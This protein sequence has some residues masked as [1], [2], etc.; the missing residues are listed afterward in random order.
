MIVPLGDLQYGSEAC[1]FDRFKRHVEWAVALPNAYFLGMGD[2]VDFGSPSNRAS[3]R[4]LIEKGEL[5]DTA[6]DLV[7]N[8]AQAHLEELLEV[9][10][11][12][13]GRWLG[14]LEGHH[15]WTFADGTTSDTRLCQALGAPFLGT[16]ALVQVRFRQAKPTHKQAPSFVI[17]CHHGRGSGQMQG[18]PLN[19]LEQVTKAF[20]ADVYL[21]GHHH[22]KASA[23][24]QRLA[25]I[26]GPTGKGRLL[27]KNVIIAGTGG[28]LK[29]YMQGSKRGSVAR[30]GYVEQGM[31]V[32]VALGGVVIWARPKQE[33][34]GYAS[35]DLDIS[36]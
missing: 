36:L 28:F 21:I 34:G 9:L 17:W 23:K 32:P 16:C 26:W 3:L 29:G 1:D 24:M 8:A 35:V 31:M 25:G 7:D 13:K 33:H 2:Y 18:S 30:G 20:D 11:P 12:T 5:Y 4:A 6:Q 22:K 27:H 19:K 15:F 14:L 10:E